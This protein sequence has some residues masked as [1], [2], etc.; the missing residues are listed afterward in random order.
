MDTVAG[1]LLTPE[2]LRDLGVDRDASRWGYDEMV[3]S[4]ELG[5]PGPAI[6]G[7]DE[8]VRV[9]LDHVRQIAPYLSTA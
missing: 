6:A 5:V 1:P 3:V 8:W 4:L 7:A 9:S 2:A